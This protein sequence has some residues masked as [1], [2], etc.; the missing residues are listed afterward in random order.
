MWGGQGRLVP[1]AERVLGQGFAPLQRGAPKSLETLGREG[2]TACSSCSS[3]SLGQVTPALKT[4]S[5]HPA[6]FSSK[7]PALALPTT[8]SAPSAL[9]FL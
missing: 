6:P 9:S 3:S 2:H 5:A 4:W 7:T 8:T 1:F